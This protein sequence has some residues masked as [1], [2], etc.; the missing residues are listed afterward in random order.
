MASSPSAPW[1]AEAGKLRNR[2]GVALDS[3][4]RIYAVDRKNL[5]LSRFD[6]MAGEGWTSFG[7]K[8]V[9]PGQITEAYSLTLDGK[10]RIIVADSHGGRIARFDDTDGS[11]W[12]T[13]SFK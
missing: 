12:R 11:G 4:G 3:K 8:G 2:Y 7:T 1:G 5:R 10:D 6:S 9:G 13:Y